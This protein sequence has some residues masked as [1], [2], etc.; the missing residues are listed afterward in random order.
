MLAIMN[1]FSRWLQEELNKREWTQADLARKASV[2]RAAVSDVMSG[3]R[4]VG[5]DLAVAIST[6]LNVP[7]AEIF[8]ANGILP[9]MAETS[10]RS[11]QVEHLLSQLPD[12]EYDGVIEYIKMRMKIKA[13]NGKTKTAVLFSA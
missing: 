9:P 8:R 5:R 3:K 13:G 6:A 10:A 12:D 7:L 11:R 2:S 4:N 1:N